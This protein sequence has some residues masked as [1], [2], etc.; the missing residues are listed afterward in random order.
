MVP[1]FPPRKQHII[2][3][4]GIDTKCNRMILTLRTKF[5]IVDLN[6]WLK[7]VFIFEIKSVKPKVRLD[8]FI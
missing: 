7:I 6:N 4:I 5:D 1:G 2:E 8:T 3:I